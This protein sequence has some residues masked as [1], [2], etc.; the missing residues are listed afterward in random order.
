MDAA[1]C[2]SYLTNGYCTLWETGS[3]RRRTFG[4]NAY[5]NC[6]TTCSICTTTT[7]PTTAPTAAPTTAPTAAPTTAAAT[8]PA[9]TPAPSQ[10]P[11]PTQAT[12]SI[13]TVSTSL[14]VSDAT[15]MCTEQAKAAYTRAFATTAGVAQSEVTVIS[16]KLSRRASVI[17]VTEIVANT[18]AAAQ[19]AADTVAS[20][21]TLVSNF[22]SES[23]A[24]SLIV[25]ASASSITSSS[26]STASSITYVGTTTSGCSF[27]CTG[28]ESGTSNGGCQMYSGSCS[29]VAPKN[30]DC[31]CDGYCIAASSSWDD[32]SCCPLDPGRFAAIL[33][34]PCLL[35]VFIVVALMWHSRLGCFNA[36]PSQTEKPTVGVQELQPA[37]TVEGDSNAKGSYDQMPPTIDQEQGQ[38]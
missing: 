14:T 19:T 8:T 18:P 38:I 35:L 24:A 12:T 21:T 23:S 11:T 26:V 20:A 16:C 36:K 7:A 31:W 22:N 13:V 3:V 17:I 6:K 1:T 10:H 30:N 33:L 29:W 28:C 27:G 4:G 34:G 2:N 5:D 37:T 25:T 15:E 9:P 32:D